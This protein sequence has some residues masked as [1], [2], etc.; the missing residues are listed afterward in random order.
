[1][2]F[3]NYRWRNF[4]SIY[5][6]LVVWKVIHSLLLSSGYEDDG[7]RKPV[8]GKALLPSLDPLPH[9]PTRI[10]PTPPSGQP[11]TDPSRP[12]SELNINLC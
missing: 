3:C 9:T 12:Q 5:V 7:S 2:D 4:K 8:P 10:T 1:M 11:P 6:I